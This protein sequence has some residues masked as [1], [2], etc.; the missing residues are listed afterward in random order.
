MLR[1]YRG[2]LCAIGLIAVIT[3]AVGYWIWP[4]QPT[5]T[6]YG[7]ADP[8]TE[9][10][11]PGGYECDITAI[12]S[13]PIASERATKADYCRQQAEEYRQ[14]TNDLIQ[15][16]RSANAAEAQA[17]IASQQL[18]TGWL[19]TLGGFLTLAAA[20]L[21]AFYAREAARH[22]RKANKIAREAERRQLRAYLT[23]TE[24]TYG[25]IITERATATFDLRFRNSGQTP[26]RNLRGVIDAYIAPQ[27]HK[28]KLP[29]L[30]RIK[31]F[32]V[33]NVGVNAD[34]GAFAR[35]FKIT[36]SQRDAYRKG[37]AHFYIVASQI[38]EDV[39][40]NAYRLDGIFRGRGTDEGNTLDALLDRETLISPKIKKKAKK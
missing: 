34:T 29:T 8:R 23:V 17:N 16:T 30:R 36:Q 6:F 9:N 14:N 1:G 19:Q 32:P 22:T 20:G 21:A 25:G 10:Y 2:I 38:Y 18:W 5:L 37:T 24:M 3:A 7:E 31:S 15:Q 11:Q 26:A 4:S 13:L 28:P 27:G 12:A 33:Q 39:F 35:P 40:G